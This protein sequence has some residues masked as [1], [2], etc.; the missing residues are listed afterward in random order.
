MASNTVSDP[1]PI[2][3][4]AASG[5]TGHRVAD[6]LEAGGHNVRRASRAAAI[7]FNWTDHSTYA[8]NLAG[9]KA[10]YIAYTPDLSIDRAEDDIKSFVDAAI[11]AG[12]E[13][14]VLMS[15][16]GEPAAER[17][18]QIVRDAAIENTVVRASWFNQNF[19]EGDFLPMVLEGTITMPVADVAEPFIDADDIAEVAYVSLTQSGHNGELYEVTGPRAI[20]FHE[21]AEILSSQT[22]RTI[23]YLPI[24]MQQFKSA[25]T[26]AGVPSGRI[27]LLD[28]VISN[29]LDGRGV[30]PQ[31]GVQR[32]LGRPAKDFRE[33]AEAAFKGKMVLSHEG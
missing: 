9:C 19:D 32:A 6:R 3:V 21:I 11:Q 1:R 13:R 2:L 30:I 27:E 28:Y 29:S 15:A 4:T 16:R 24:T 18:E 8:P 17:C 12:V 23:T 25:L 14:L 22:S 33:Y 7:P 31:D 10:A 5:K 26:D 20:T